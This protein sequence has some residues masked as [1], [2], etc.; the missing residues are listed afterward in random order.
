MHE[1]IPETRRLRAQPELAHNVDAGYLGT[2]ALE[3]LE[4]PD[5]ALERRDAVS[6][7]RV[8]GIHARHSSFVSEFFWHRLML[9]RGRCRG[10]A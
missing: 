2:V 4:D 6:I 8:A 10:A 1:T 7:D 3:E 5:P 9:C